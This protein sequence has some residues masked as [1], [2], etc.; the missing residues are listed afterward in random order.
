MTEEVVPPTAHR[1]GE[2]PFIE[3]LFSRLRLRA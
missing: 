1:R 3:E 2:A